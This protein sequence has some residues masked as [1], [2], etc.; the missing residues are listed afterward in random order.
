M[1][2]AEAAHVAAT[3]EDKLAAEKAAAEAAKP[4]QKSGQQVASLPPTNGPEPN[5]LSPIEVARLLQSELRR[6]G[7]SSG[8]IDGN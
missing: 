2:K 4:E 7:C 1:E 6:V 3:T 5:L 8:S